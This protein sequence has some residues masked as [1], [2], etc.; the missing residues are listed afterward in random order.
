MTRYAFLQVHCVKCG[1]LGALITFYTP[2][3]EASSHCSLWL[4]IPRQ[5]DVSWVVSIG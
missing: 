2:T 3:V 4:E 1:L 5:G